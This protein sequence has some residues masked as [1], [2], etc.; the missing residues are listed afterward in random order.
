M[1][2]SFGGQEEQNVP[3][4]SYISNPTTTSTS[5]YGVSGGSLGNITTTGLGGLLGSQQ[6]DWNVYQQQPAMQ[7]LQMMA[8]AV[9]TSETNQQ[10][11][12]EI[13][14]RLIRY[15]VVDP[16]PK[17]AEQKPEN[18]ILMSGT[19]MLNGQDDKGFLMELAPKIQEKLGAHNTELSGMTWEDKDGKS[20]TFRGRRLSNLDVVIEVLK[21][22]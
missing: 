13:V 4:V 16:D 1:K 6:Y 17:L 21:S 22:Y 2:I 19:A 20:H 14:A 10:K 5:G 3:S 12:K 11:E 18:S 7:A 8:K 15:T 9:T